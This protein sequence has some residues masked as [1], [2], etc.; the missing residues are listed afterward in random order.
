MIEKIED[1]E[2]AYSSRVNE[3]LVYESIDKLSEIGLS[4]FDEL[5]N[6]RWSSQGLKMPSLSGR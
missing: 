3:L 2:I 4:N 1:K 6:Q 5:K